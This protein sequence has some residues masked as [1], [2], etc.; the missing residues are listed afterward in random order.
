M[1][2]V[3]TIDLSSLA[4]SSGL[5]SL[6]V[7]WYRESRAEGEQTVLLES[8]DALVDHIVL[9]SLVNLLLEL[10]HQHGLLA[11]SLP[12]GYCPESGS[13]AARRQSLKSA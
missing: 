2:V 11:L 4:S 6:S 13:F 10:E 5:L 3:N 1:L 8:L 12:A 7:Y 9:V